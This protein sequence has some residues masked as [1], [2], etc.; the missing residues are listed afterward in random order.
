MSPDVEH[1]EHFLPDP[2]SLFHALVDEISWDDRMHAR[3][4][5]SFGYA[6][7]YSGIHYPDGPLDGLPGEIATRVSAHLGHPITNCLANFYAREDSAMGFH[8]DS[9]ERLHPESSIAIVSLGAPR[10]I[11]FRAKARDAGEISF[12]LHGGS[13]FVMAPSVQRAWKHAVPAEP[14]ARPRISLTFRWI[15]DPA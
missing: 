11:V 6:Y 2:D 15:V 8:A 7:D 3:R 1:I 12:R 13:L 4:T 5:A 9:Y 10:T 14:G